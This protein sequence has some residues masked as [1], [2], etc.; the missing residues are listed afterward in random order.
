MKIR[1]FFLMGTVMITACRQPS[2]VVAVDQDSLAHCASK[3]PSRF[4]GIATGDSIIQAADSASHLGMVW[5]KEGSFMMGAQDQEG[6]EDEYPAH[7]VTVNGFWMD[8][9]EVTNEAFQKFV[10]ATGYITTAEK[11]PDWN[12]LKKQLPP[13]TPKPP[14]SV[15]VAASL[16]FVKQPAGVGLGDPSIWW[17]WKKGANWKHPNGPGS[18]IKGKGN[19]PVVHVS[20]DDAMAYCKWSGKRLPT[21]A[22]WEYAA[23]AG[24]QNSYPWGNEQIEKGKPKANTWQGTFPSFNTS[25]DGFDNAAPVKSFQ[26]NA[27]GLY[28]MAGN[29]WEWCAD[30]YQHDYYKEVANQKIINP[31]GPN[32]SYDPDEPTVPK[33]VVR[34][35]SFLCNASYCKGYRV[36]ARMK[37]ATDT[38][39]EH[40]GF[41]CVAD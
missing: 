28:D 10:D 19:Y 12:E 2:T 39:L 41:R 31:V 18:S 23:R 3:L 9:T 21:E 27:F 40:T 6:R 13:G 26:S 8:A 22:E 25:W 35:G 5:I 16:V 11:A 7:S 30:W 4:G 17:T 36:S 38:G 37:T 20:W 29:V 32:T 1:L 14:D 34:G 33:K 15:L 24:V